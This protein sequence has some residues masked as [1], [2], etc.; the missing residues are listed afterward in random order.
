MNNKI[1]KIHEYLLKIWKDEKR[2]ENYDHSS[3]GLAMEIAIYAHRNQKRE[4]NEDY[5]NHPFRVL[6]NY[7]SFVGLI[8]GTYFSIDQDLMFEHKI[9]Y[10]GVQEVCL[11]HDVVEDTD[12]TIEDIKEIYSEYE[13][14]DFFEMYIEIPLKN[15]THDKTIDYLDYIRI[16][17]KN[18][19]SALVKMMD[20][21][22]NL[23]VVDLIK[24]TEKELNR[25]INYVQYI[26]IINSVYH[27]LENAKEYRDE[28]Q[29]NDKNE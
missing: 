23:R 29:E 3:V 18:P 14:K 5:V 8:P 11:L 20:L 13:L 26:Y 4:N 22:D 24:L 9:P 21:Q 28:F 27:F 17:L 12:F 6:D 10:Q 7:R 2:I 15:I 19:T 16:C 25:A 1:I